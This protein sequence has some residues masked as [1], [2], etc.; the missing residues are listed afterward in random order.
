MGT[1][2]TSLTTDETI[3]ATRKLIDAEGVDAF[4][5]RKLAAVLD[6]NPM[7]IYKRFTNK[8][9]LLA[10]VAAETLDEIEIPE[11]QGT[12]DDQA[13]AL[14]HALRDGLLADRGAAAAL[15]G[16]TAD[17]PAAVVRLTDHGL[18]LMEEI[19]YRGDHAITAFRVLFWHAVGAALSRD[20]MVAV[21]PATTDTAFSDLAPDVPTYARLRARFGPIDP[22]ELFSVAT[23]D[24]VAGLRLS[25]EQEQH[26]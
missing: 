17:M 12:W 1:R 3:A 15:I 11:R 4:S 10:A 16:V 7:T 26:D 8:E 20:A 25:A 24:L 18:V 23:R 22:D 6:V 5:M 19:G 13:A 21:T 9:A 14:A 2:A